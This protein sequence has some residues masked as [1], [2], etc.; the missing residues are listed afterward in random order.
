MRKIL[1]GNGGSG[2]GKGKRAKSKEQRAKSKE[3]RAKSKEQSGLLAN[4]N[5]WRKCS[6]VSGA[7]DTVKGSRFNVPLI[8]NL[9]P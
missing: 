3:Q 5:K 1:C 2:K 4:Q 7:H 6:V 9:E 8:S